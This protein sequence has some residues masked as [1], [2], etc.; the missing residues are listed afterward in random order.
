MLHIFTHCV[1]LSKQ[2]RVLHHLTI[3]H[4]VDC[5]DL[6][7]VVHKF[8]QRKIE[9]I[10]NKLYGFQRLFTAFCS[11]FVVFNV[12]S[13]QLVRNVLTI[14]RFSAFSSHFCG[15]PT[16]S[17][18]SFTFHAFFAISWEFH[19][20]LKRFLCF[21]GGFRPFPD[22]FIVIIQ[23]IQRNLQKSI[24]KNLVTNFDLHNDIILEAF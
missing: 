19:S 18:H 10:D 17:W 5:S 16:F 8:M 22:T 21:F 3:W 14:L 20:F 13:L 15:F 12:Y 1:W 9:R 6:F 4:A 23:A 24:K 11:K 2:I 7:S